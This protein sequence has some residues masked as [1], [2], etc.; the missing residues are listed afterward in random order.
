MVYCEDSYDIPYRCLVPKTIDNLLVAG[1]CASTT[2]EAHGST[3][4]M[5]T[6]MALGE[7]AGTAARIA[8]ADGVTPRKVNVDKVREALLAEGAYLGE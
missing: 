2:H 5:S 7:A 8:V 6:C 1:R 3:R 4:V